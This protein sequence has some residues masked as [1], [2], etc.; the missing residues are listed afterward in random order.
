VKGLIQGDLAA[1][2]SFFLR[3]KGRFESFYLTDPDD[4]KLV[5]QLIGL[6]DGVNKNFQAIRTLGGGGGFSEP[7]FKFNGT[8]TI[9]VGGTLYES[10]AVDNMG[11][12]SFADAPELGSEI[13]ITEGSFYFRVRFKQDIQEYSKFYSNLWNLKKC[14]LISLKGDE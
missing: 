7:I 13:V 5:N 11:I 6:G 12:I 4:N 8:P 1:I 10:F 3:R 2:M 14:E 9:T